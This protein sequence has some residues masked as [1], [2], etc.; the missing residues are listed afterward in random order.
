MSDPA[1]TPV[2][3]VGGGVSGLAC[4]G[5]LAAAG[6]SVRVL[7]R[8]RGV[9]GR[10]ATRRLEGQPVDH[11]VAFLHG[12]DPAFLAELSRVPA[13][14]LPGWPAAVSGVG[15]PCQPE[16]FTPGEQR[17]AFAEGVVALP[18]HL[19]VGLDVRLGV[20]VTALEAGAIGPGLRTAGGD[21]LEGQDVV[22]AL[23]AEQAARL[24]R[25]LEPA[26]TEIAAAVAL[27]GFSRS[28]ACLSLLALYPDDAPRPAWQVCYPESSRVL[29]LVVHDSAKRPAPARLALVLQGRPGWSRAHL[30][31]PGWEAA[32]L[33]EAARLL[34]PWAGHPA[35]SHAHRWTFAR[36]DR[37]SELAGPMLVDLPG[38]GRLGLCGDRFARGGG[39][40][41]A[42]RSG[43]MMAERL[44]AAGGRRD[45]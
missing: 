25:T 9:G 33:G 23:A 40:E 39:V 42:W 1:G 2:L 4:A 12:R 34:G 43:R 17:L 7:E 22:L 5:A 18:R 8:A 24:L 27:L 36:S 35:A 10:C 11:G 14:P 6:R 15:L 26:P 29:Q 21:L 37:A 31:D 30:D 13:T 38:G 44:L 32:L 45:G 16:A 28:Q 20:E 3:V 41:G 19:A